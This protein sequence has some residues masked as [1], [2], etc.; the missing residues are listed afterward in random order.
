MKVDLR[1]VLPTSAD[2]LPAVQRVTPANLKQGTQFEALVNQRERR[3]RRSLR[4]DLEQAEQSAPVNAELFSTTRSLQVL[5]YLL[6]T[7][8][9]GL[10]AEPEIRELAEMFI[11]EEIDT[12]LMLQ[13]QRTEVE[14]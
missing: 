11:R 10:D 12:R 13:Q 2:Q 14:E 5:D 9:P 4:A 7:V 8:L 1:S 3:I 6:D